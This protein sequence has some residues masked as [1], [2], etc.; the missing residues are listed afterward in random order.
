M[1]TLTGQSHTAPGVP[2]PALPEDV[3]VTELGIAKLRAYLDEA[4]LA[5]YRIFHARLSE[6]HG[7][8]HVLSRLDPDAVWEAA[9]GALALK[10]GLV[11]IIFDDGDPAVAPRA[12]Q[13]GFLHLR[14]IQVVVA[15]WYWI[16]DHGRTCAM[17]FVAAPQA[18]C[19]GRLWQKLIELSRT[20]DKPFW[21]IATEYGLE[22][23][24][25]RVS[26]D[27][28]HLVLDEA[29]ERRIETEVIGFFKP[30]VRALY[31]RL[32]VPYRRGV[33][34]YGEPGNGKT[35]LIRSIGARLPDVSAILLRPGG[36]FNTDALSTTLTTW[37]QHAPALLV[38]EDLGYV[39]DQVNVST[40]LNLLDGVDQRV[41]GGLL[42]IATTNHPD[43][44]DPALSNRPGRFDVTIE[45]PCPRRPARELYFRTRLLEIDLET[46][47]RLV[48]GSEG[49]SFSHMEEIVRLSGLLALKSGRD[50]RITDDVLSAMRMT[51]EAFDAA[52][53]GFVRKP[54]SPFGL[55]PLH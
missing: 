25:P 4:K 38:I 21:H 44:L 2:L 55:R 19:I 23:R 48:E 13:G 28:S 27:T 34:M 49:L 14:S 16:G 46:V 43:W 50:V 17:Y 18:E 6:L 39:L 26:C 32:G 12:W 37:A 36:E 3:V 51:R 52:V 10:E 30:G 15:R 22:S 47:G 40:F 41:R 53:S 42:L 31:E 1:L 7:I 33:L 8:D 45:L 11:P 5:E 20:G 35:S 54:E 9:D 24:S 29:L